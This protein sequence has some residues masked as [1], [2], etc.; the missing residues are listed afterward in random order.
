MM[1]SPISPIQLPVYL[2]IGQKRTLAGALDWPGWCRGGRGEETAL[3]A[4][5]EYGP[6][7]GRVLQ[8]AGLRFETPVDIARLAVA[9]RLEGNT[10]TDFGAP[11][12]P[13]SVDAAP[14]DDAELRRLQALL[15]A[16]WLAFDAAIQAAHGKDL[17]KGPRGGGREL[18]GIVEH[19][20]GA[21][22]SYVARLGGKVPNHEDQDDPLRA[23]EQRRTIILDVLAAAARGEVPPVRPR[24]GA[25]WTPR[26]FVRRAAWHVLDHVWEIEDRAI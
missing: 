13:P 19:V 20:L 22:A 5:V 2:E 4:L 1:H 17:R 25:R 10:T 14:V 9:E 7:Y 18:I 11:D 21:E 8:A 23:M 3:R 26:F 6:R 16:C 12:V 15:N 24:G